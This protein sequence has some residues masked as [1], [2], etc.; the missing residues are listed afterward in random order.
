[1]DKALVESTILINLK[2]FPRSKVI[3]S[4]N[5]QRRLSVAAS[6]SIQ[7]AVVADQSNLSDITPLTNSLSNTFS[8]LTGDSLL[9]ALE[10]AILYL[11][12]N[13]TNFN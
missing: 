3:N 8:T 12:I 6:T 13:K 4:P 7:D 2:E 9:E 1:M 11:S 5:N 10:Y